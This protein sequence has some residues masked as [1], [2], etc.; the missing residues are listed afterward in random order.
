MKI[1]GDSRAGSREGTSVA[2]AYTSPVIPARLRE[3]GNFR[4]YGRPFKTWAI[5]TRFEDD[6]RPTCP[7]AEDVE[8]PATYVDRLPDLWNA[9]SVTPASDL[10]INDAR[11]KACCYQKRQAL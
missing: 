11:Y 8:S 9:A 7:R 4:L 2:P 1:T 6:W 3:L 10:F 5:S